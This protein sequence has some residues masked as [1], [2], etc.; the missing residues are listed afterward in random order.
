MASPGHCL[1]GPGVRC[2][3][4]DVPRSHRHR[5]PVLEIAV[6]ASLLLLLSGLADPEPRLVWNISSSAPRGL[7][8]ISRNNDHAPG[9]FAA[10]W[11]EAGVADLAAQR[12]Y[13]PRGIPLIKEVAAVTGDE[14]CASGTGI[15]LFGRLIA[16]RLGD[17]PKGRSMPWWNGCRRL[18]AGEVLLLNGSNPLS[19][20]GRYFGPSASSRVIGRARLIWRR[21]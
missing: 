3:C 13:L 14:V 12:H 9:Q 1:P 17:D 6:A 20:D 7:Y 4:A 15:F 19:F 11:L 10:T 16:T 21:D 2:R 18:G 8:W 5:Q